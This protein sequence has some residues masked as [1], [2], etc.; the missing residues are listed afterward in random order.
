MRLLLFF[1]L[2]LIS[3]SAEQR[4]WGQDYDPSFPVLRFMPHPLQKL[5]HKIE[6]HNAT[7]LATLLHEVRTDWQQK[8]HLL[9]ALYT[10][11]TSLYNLDNKLKGTRWSNGIQ[12][13]VI[14]TMPL[15]DWND[16]VTDMK[17]RTILSDMIPAYFFHTK[18]LISY[19]LFHYMHMRDG[20]GHARKMVR[21]TLPNCEKLA[22]VSEVFKFYKTH[23]G[24]DPTSLRVLK[25]FMSLLKWLELGNRLQHIKEDVFA[26]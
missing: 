17:I 7:F 22:K 2:A 4:P 16:E 3:L 13:S 21:K 1:L 8:D 9:E 15:D 20:L 5:I 25:D 11:D 24:E 10:D 26:D 6:K 14:A 12:H 19:A 18:Y 23:R